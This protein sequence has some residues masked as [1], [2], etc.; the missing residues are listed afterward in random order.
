MAWNRLQQ[1]C[2]A[3]KITLSTSQTD[4]KY[5]KL[6]YRSWNESELAFPKSKPSKLE[7]QLP[8]LLAIV[9]PLK[10][11]MLVNWAWWLVPS[12]PALGRMKQEEQCKSKASL[13]HTASFRPA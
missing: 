11:K 6:V 5:F 10:E 4:D 12:M 13:S 3:G 7:V 9:L 2:I 1:K 8:L